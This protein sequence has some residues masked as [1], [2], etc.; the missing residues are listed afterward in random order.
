MYFV[1]EFLI[2]LDNFVKLAAE[3]DLEMVETLNFHDFYKKYIS[4]REHFEFFKSRNFFK[5]PHDK[6]L[7]EDAEWDCSYLYRTIMFR[8]TTRVEQTNTLRDF[9]DPYY[10]K[11]I[12]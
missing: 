9:R 6:Y 3:Y 12:K 5:K 11:L 7:M 8:K 10:F 1:P 4:S 2:V